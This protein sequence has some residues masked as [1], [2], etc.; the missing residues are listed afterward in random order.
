M[1][2]TT[3]CRVQRS[4]ECECFQIPEKMKSPKNTNVVA[5]KWIRNWKT[6]DRGDVIK[7]KSRMAARYFGQIHTVEFFETLA[8]TPSAASV[9]I[10]EAVENEK[11]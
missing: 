9:K 2:E 4:V 11:C 1:F 7:P 10:T 8:S 5:G 3:L 6:D